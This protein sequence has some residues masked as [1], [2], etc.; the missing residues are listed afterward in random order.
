VMTQRY[1]AVAAVE[2]KETHGAT[3][4]REREAV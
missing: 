4:P 3:H 2:V 1:V